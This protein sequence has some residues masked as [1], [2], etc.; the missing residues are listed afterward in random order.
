VLARQ[1]SQSDNLDQL[2]GLINRLR[3]SDRLY[4]KIARRQGGAIVL[5]EVMPALPPSV[6]STL[7]ANRGRGEVTPLAETTIHEESIPLDQLVVGGSLV[8]ITVK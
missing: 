2:I 8:L 4:M 5:N 3:T 7:N 6:Q 1:V